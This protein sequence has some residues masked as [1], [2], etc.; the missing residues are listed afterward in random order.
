[1]TNIFTIGF[2]G[3]SPE[4]Q[5]LKSTGPI[6]EG[7]YVAR[8]EKLQ[9]ITPYG[10]A[11]GLANKGTWPGSLYSWGASRIPSEASTNT[12]TFDRGGFYIHGGWEPGSAGCIDLTSSMNDFT[13]WFENNGHDLVVDVEY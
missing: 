6:P 4:Y 2:S 11:F 8:Q 13:K 7:T 3:K 1:M 10:L 9:H 12:N 5:N